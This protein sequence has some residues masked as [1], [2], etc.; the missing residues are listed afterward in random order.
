MKFVIALYVFSI[1]SVLIGCKIQEV[2][3][4]N[5]LKIF[6]NEQFDKKYSSLTSFNLRNEP[7]LKDIIKLFKS[8]NT[9]D[10]LEDVVILEFLVLQSCTNDKEIKFQDYPNELQSIFDFYNSM[11]KEEIEWLNDKELK[12]LKFTSIRF[13]AN[14]AKDNEAIDHLKNQLTRC[15]DD[16]DYASFVMSSSDLN[17]CIE[18]RNN[19]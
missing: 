5:Q 12:I 3:L 10:E 18:K 2:P 17:E 15:K 8:K 4:S 13:I 14:Y 7:N 1:L 6:N 9:N 11:E 16:K 19:Q